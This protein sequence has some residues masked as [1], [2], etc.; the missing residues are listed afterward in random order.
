MKKKRKEAI[1]IEQL[2]ILE[3]GSEGVCI[4][5]YE[6][7]VVFVPY[8]V[9]G[10]VVDVQVFKRK[11][12]YYEGK[13]V[14]L[15]TAS[16]NRI[17]PQ[18]E[19]FGLCGGCK[20]QNMQYETQLFYKRKQ[21]IDNFQRIGKFPFPEVNPILASESVFA[22]RNKVEYTFSNKRWLEKEEMDTMELLDTNGLGFHL[23]GMFDKI[24]DIHHCYLHEKKGN[25]IRDAIKRYAIDNQLEFWN[26]RQQTG[27]LRNLIIRTAVSGDL[28]VIVVFTALTKQARQLL[29]FIRESFPYITS[30]IYV[31]NAKKNDSITDLPTHTYHGS[32]FM[33]E[34]MNQLQFKV[35]PLAFYQTNAKQAL[36]LY[37]VTARFANATKNEIVYD[38]YTGT[39]TIALFLA[40]AAKKVVGIECVESAIENAVEN[41]KLNNITNADFCAGDMAKVFTND[42]VAKNGKPDVIIADPPR[43]GMHPKV[44]EQ[45]VNI[46]P[47]RMVYVSCNPATQARD[48]A[49]MADFYEITEVQPVDMFPHTH[50]VENVALLVKKGLKSV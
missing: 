4:G 9:P 10:D 27:L 24:L 15:H 47:Q 28:M 45:I 11:R 16:P 21:V 6:E 48:I 49:L 34:Q 17:T 23:P 44:V 31:E 14:A 8:V 5:K 18:C 37:E 12:S 2:H 20:W 50:H 13:A 22:Y 30:L 46:A 42:F 39:G 40:S 25:D 35:S 19:H 38:L 36:K 3:A 43:S 29:D 32:D 1:T 33:I 41:A 26:P 7:R